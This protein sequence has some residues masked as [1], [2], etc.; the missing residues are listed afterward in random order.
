MELFLP[1]LIILVLLGFFIFLILPRTGSMV[2]SVICLIALIAAGFH[3]FNM[4]YSEYTLSTWQYSLA[5]YAPWV[6]LGVSF[7][8]I[9]SAIMYMFAD[10][11]T[12]A[13]VPD[14]VKAPIEQI[15]GAVENAAAIMPS[16]AS[17]TNAVTGYINRA[18]NTNAQGQGQ[19]Q[20]QRQNRNRNSPVLPGGFKASEY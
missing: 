2:L 8:F 9:I 5:A 17:A 16:A 7:V 11:D 18:L 10:S 14:V 4:F 12:K 13:M 1:S 19:G 15:Q 20:E 6:V 3:H